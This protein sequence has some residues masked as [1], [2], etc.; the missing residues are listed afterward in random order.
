MV[1]D[2]FKELFFE[3]TV[4]FKGGEFYEEEESLVSM[5]YEKLFGYYQV[6]SSLC[7][8]VKKCLL[9]KKNVKRS[10]TEKQEIRERKWW[11]E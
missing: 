5:I 10:P 4:D 9:D 7:H 8:K 6:F 1:V 2:G 3:T 11:V